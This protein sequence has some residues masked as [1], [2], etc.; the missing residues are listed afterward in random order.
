MDSLVFCLDAGAD[1]I[2]PVHGETFINIG[3]NDG[4]PDEYTPFHSPR[5]S[6]FFAQLELFY[7]A[8]VVLEQQSGLEARVDAIQRELVLVCIQVAK[9][10]LERGA[11]DSSGRRLVHL[12]IADQLDGGDLGIAHQNWERCEPSLTDIRR[13]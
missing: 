5:W 6:A 4:A 12:L 7:K 11:L 2:D 13:H 9:G 3:L 10:A 1:E 8:R